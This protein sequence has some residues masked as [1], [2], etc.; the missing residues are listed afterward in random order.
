MIRHRREAFVIVRF[1]FF[2]LTKA[3]PKDISF[4]PFPFSYIVANPRV[5][6]TGPEVTETGQN[7]RLLIQKRDISDKNGIERFLNGSP[8]RFRVPG[9]QEVGYKKGTIG[10]DQWQIC[11]GEVFT[12]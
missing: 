9:V 11:K 7:T 4:S 5:T 12:L 1:S 10:A 8:S 2:S 3:T 6:E